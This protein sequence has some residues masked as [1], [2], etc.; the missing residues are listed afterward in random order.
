MTGYAAQRDAAIGEMYAEGRTTKEIAD[1]YGVSPRTVQ[2]ALARCGIADEGK[3]A[4]PHAFDAAIGAMMADGLPASWCAEDVP[5]HVE[6]IR[7]VARGLPGRREA[8]RE[9]AR[10][11][12]EI[13]RSETL[14]ELHRQFAPTRDLRI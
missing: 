1:Y 8:V 11:W 12:Q 14:F 13:R 10:V 7:Q 6:T 9:W 4:A 2:R 5:L 3:R